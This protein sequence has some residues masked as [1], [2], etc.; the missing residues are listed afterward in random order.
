MTVLKWYTFVIILL[1]YLINLY[2]HAKDDDLFG[3]LVI[4]IMT[5]PMLIYIFLS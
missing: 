2:N 3:F 5:M 4:L 1:S